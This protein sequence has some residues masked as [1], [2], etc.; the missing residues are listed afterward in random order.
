MIFVNGAP[1]DAHSSSS[2]SSTSS[3]VIELGTSAYEQ[4]SAT[5]RALM[6][7]PALVSASNSFKDRPMRKFKIPVIPEESGPGTSAKTK[8][9]YLFQREYA[10]VDPALVD[11]VGTDEATTCVGVAITNRRNRL[12]SV[13]HMDSPDIVN[14]GLN[15][16]LSSFTDCCSND[17]LDVHIIGGFED[18]LPNHDNESSSSESEANLDG[19]S[20]PLCS[21][22]VE[23]LKTREEKFHL[24]TLCV[25]THNTRRDFEGNAYPIFNGLVVETS[26]GSVFPA[27]FDT[28]SRCPDEIVR[29]IRVTASFEDHEWDH[30]LLE[31]Y[32]TQTDRFVIAPCRWTPRQA[33]IARSLTHLSESEVL[34]ICSTSP[35]AEAPDF[36]ENERRKWDYLIQHPDWRSTF[37]REQPRVFERTADGG[38]KRC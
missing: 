11:F 37:P 6:K 3:Q 33:V 31:T 14:M 21:T 13:A 27:S 15:Q 4:G 18:F 20:F 24:Q 1:F 16:M 28:T 12:T 22:I 34:Q 38:W 8:W 19:Y 5:L 17:D 36:V 2:S 29:R 26:T 10:T 9:V 35:A 32:N 25:L 7:D 23:T 30:K